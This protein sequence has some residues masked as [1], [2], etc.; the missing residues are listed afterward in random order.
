[1]GEL[2]DRSLSTPS[3]VQLSR[4][5]AD[6]GNDHLIAPA[7]VGSLGGEMETL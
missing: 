6:L 1:M 5:E 3:A 4:N 7:G 2:H